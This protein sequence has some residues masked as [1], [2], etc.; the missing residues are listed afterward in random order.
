MITVNDS[1][2]S[3]QE[4]KAGDNKSI[5]DRNNSVIT[6]DSLVEGVID[7]DMKNKTSF[8][9]TPIGYVKNKELK[10]IEKE[11]ERHDPITITKT[12]MNILNSE[13]QSSATVEFFKY[14]KDR[15]SFHSSL[16]LKMTSIIKE[17]IPA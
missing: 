1:D 3:I 16:L 15:D 2:A 17:I 10:E 12:I 4:Q 7:S 11:I 14:F 9:E 13:N 6:I 5:Q 8:R